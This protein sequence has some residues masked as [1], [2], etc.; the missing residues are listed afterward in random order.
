MI[1]ALLALCMAVVV[2]ALTGCGPASGTVTNT[3]WSYVCVRD[4][5]GAE[6]CHKVRHS[7]A[8]RCHAGDRW[9][10]CGR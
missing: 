8:V 4:S 7:V 10:D 9:P 6:G 3:R 1:R 2:V 5:F